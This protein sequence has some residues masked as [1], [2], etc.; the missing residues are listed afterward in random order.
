[1]TTQ[2]KCRDECG[3]SINENKIEQ[4]FRG[5]ITGRYRCPACYQALKNIDEK[6]PAVAGEGPSLT[7]VP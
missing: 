2:R 3:A 4:W 6:T 5:E 1:M 7:K